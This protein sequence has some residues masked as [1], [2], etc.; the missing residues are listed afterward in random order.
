[1]GTTV[2]FLSPPKTSEP[3]NASTPPFEDFIPLDP[4][5]TIRDRPPSK[6]GGL[7]DSDDGPCY[8]Q[9]L[10]TSIILSTSYFLL[11][12]I[13]EFNCPLVAKFWPPGT[14][15]ISYGNN[16]FYFDDNDY[17]TNETEASAHC[18]YCTEEAAIYRDHYDT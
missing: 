18:D 13:R 8:S 7:P 14:D 11:Q 16:V 2:D 5:P 17:G 1:M 15:K 3:L 12:H 4:M 9:H 6:S 10:P